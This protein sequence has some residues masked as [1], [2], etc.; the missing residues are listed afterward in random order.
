[1]SASSP[2]PWAVHVILTPKP[3]RRDEVVAVLRGA[4]GRIRANE[5]ACLFLAA[6]TTED[7]D[8]VMLYELWSDRDS[9]TSFVERPDMVDYLADLDTRLISR[10]GSQWA[11]ATV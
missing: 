4:F 5:Q 11:R 3:G 1:M 9:F 2:G 8:D 7:S 6:H 10:T